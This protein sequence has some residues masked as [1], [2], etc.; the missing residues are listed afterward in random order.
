MRSVSLVCCFLLRGVGW[1]A[2]VLLH[3]HKDVPPDPFRCYL[4]ARMVFT[5]KLSISTKYVS[6]SYHIS[7]Q[8][9]LN[10]RVLK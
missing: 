2:V 5:K 7:R 9:N 1:C 8:E 6:S 10:Q 4:F 3:N